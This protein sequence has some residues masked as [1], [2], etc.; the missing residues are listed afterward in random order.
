MD[1][2]DFGYVSFL[3][4]KSVK[5]LYK[6]YLRLLEDLFEKHSIPEEDFEKARNR[7][8]DKGNDSI[9]FFKEQVDNYYF[10]HGRE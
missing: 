1:N 8:L 9:R 4:E 5:F 3:G 2:K 6:D 7:V 10:L